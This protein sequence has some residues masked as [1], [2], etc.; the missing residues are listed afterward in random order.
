MNCSYFYDFFRCCFT[1]S[2]ILGKYV[3]FEKIVV[4]PR[5]SVSSQNKKIIVARPPDPTANK[6]DAGSL[7]MIANNT[8]PRVSVN[9]KTVCGLLKISHLY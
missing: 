5:V 1:G 3:S 2:N 4:R 8:G 6:G 9:R 7:T